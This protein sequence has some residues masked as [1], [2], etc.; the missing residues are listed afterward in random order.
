MTVSMKKKD[1]PLSLTTGA[2]E[3]YSDIKELI[4]SQIF[5]K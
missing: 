5:E 2:T 1:I 4:F 3:A